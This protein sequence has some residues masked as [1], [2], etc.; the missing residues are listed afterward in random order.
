[1]S[2]Y[3]IILERHGDFNNAK[4]WQRTEFLCWAPVQDWF[5]VIKESEKFK[6]DKFMKLLS[7]FLDNDLQQILWEFWRKS[8]WPF[9]H[10]G[11]LE[12]LRKMKN[13]ISPR[14]EQLES[15]YRPREGSSDVTRRRQKY[16]T[17]SILLF[18]IINHWTMCQGS[19][20]PSQILKVS[21]F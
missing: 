14:S 2:S 20:S 8:D 10:L 16:E 6:F 1:M 15:R 5:K 9:K 7:W 4:V 19:D 11:G 12:W 13:W 17:R 21:M 3:L 18:Y